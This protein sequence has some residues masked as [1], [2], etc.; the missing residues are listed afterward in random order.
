M[1]VARV[2]S[3]VTDFSR[4][5]DLSEVHNALKYIGW[6]PPL[7]GNYCLFCEQYAIKCT[8]ALIVPSF[9]GQ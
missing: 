6:K 8:D 5:I 9:I 1:M 2:R 3:H 4:E 7:E